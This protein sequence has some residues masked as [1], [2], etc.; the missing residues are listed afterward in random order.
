MAPLTLKQCAQIFYSLHYAKAAFAYFFG[1]LAQEKTDFCHGCALGSETG[2]VTAQYEIFG[3]VFLGFFY[4]AVA[5]FDSE[6]A[7]RNCISFGR[8]AEVLNLLV[9]VKIGQ[10]AL[11]D[12]QLMLA[13]IRSGVSFLLA[14]LA[15]DVW[16]KRASG[17]GA[18]KGAGKFDL[19][20]IKT[21][22]QALFLESL[23]LALYSAYNLFT[24]DADKLRP[25]DAG[26]Y[27]AYTLAAA[28][29]GAAAL[30]WAVG[31]AEDSD[32]E[33]VV[34]YATYKKVV[35]LF[36]LSVLAAPFA[37]AANGENGL[38]GAYLTSLY[39]S[40]SLVHLLG[41]VEPSSQ[42]K[43]VFL[44]ASVV[45]FFLGSLGLF[46]SSATASA[47]YN[48]AA[49]NGASG[50]VFR[51]VGL[52][53]VLVGA[54]F[55]AFSLGFEAD[56]FEKSFAKAYGALLAWNLYQGTEFEFGVLTDLMNV[57][58]LWCLYQNYS[59]EFFRRIS[60]IV[61][62]FLK[63]PFKTVAAIASPKSSPKAGSKKMK[64]GRSSTPGR[65]SK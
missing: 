56:S 15:V 40:V 38:T 53:A 17:K 11:D 20:D 28:Q 47:F 43:L 64:R 35:E 1:D 57:F 50:S 41:C 45:S 2:Y 42:R 60:P 49:L 46:H 9:L 59:A 30:Y 12:K 27:G 55:Y 13:V 34:K 7:Q 44:V 33:K 61:P 19:F 6:R 25:N 26:V 4:T 54:S 29:F 62:S 10:G 8:V 21:G 22:T 39:Y 52:G 65:K 63:K 18:S 14:T 31:T 16:H 5:R 58:L 48:I 24:G 3:D 51:L 36:W 23:A 32:Q 37:I